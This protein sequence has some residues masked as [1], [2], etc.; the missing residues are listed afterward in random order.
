MPSLEV[1]PLATPLGAV[2]GGVDLAGD[3]DDSAVADIRKALL[4]HKV[5]F[6]HDQRLDPVTQVALARRFGEPTEAHPVEPA[7]EGH[8]EVL[9]LDS[10][11]GARA[12]VWHTDLTF[13]EAPPL[14]AILHAV[15]VPD[16]GGDTLWADM[17]AAYDALSP[18]L[19]GFLDGLTATH[20]PGK[21]DTYFEQRDTT[22]G[23]KSAKT[24]SA[25]PMHHPVVRVHPETGRPSLF[26]NPLF[27]TK[28]DGLR[29]RE[30]SAL[31]DVVQQV[32]TQP[33][34][35]VR[36][37]WQAGDVAFWDNRCTMHYALLDYR[38]RR[39]MERVAIEGDRPVGPG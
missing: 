39:R 36:W 38:S 23:D 16:V 3:L 1:S 6:F 18:A 30:S 9:A 17:A 28:I 37:R 12:D 14:G 22:A 26:V 5:L 13:Q 31:L 8:P 4:D 35:V 21:A 25:P 32:A 33:E 34:H 2:V 27:T 11:E 19:R 24:A 29:R 20:T 15:E 10:E 7:V